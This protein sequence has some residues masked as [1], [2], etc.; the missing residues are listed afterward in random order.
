MNISSNQTLYDL[1]RAHQAFIE[2]INDNS[3]DVFRKHLEMATI[4]HI[5]SVTEKGSIDLARFWLAYLGPVLSSDYWSSTVRY[6]LDKFVIFVLKKDLVGQIVKGSI[7]L[8][9]LAL[10]C[11]A[12]SEL[13][14]MGCTYDRRYNVGNIMK[15]WFSEEEAQE[16]MNSLEACVTLLYG[17]HVWALYNNDVTRGFQLPCH[18]WVSQ[19]PLLH[20]DAI[21]VSMNSTS[22][23]LP[24]DLVL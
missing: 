6:L 5:N 8:P 12:G 9:M 11:L 16:A 4:K 20:H 22:S 10:V 23:S 24:L 19:I 17:E 18:L 2:D 1:S 21:D 3:K 15:K 13:K 14:R 7:H